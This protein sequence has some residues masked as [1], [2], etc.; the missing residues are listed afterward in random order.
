MNSAPHIP[1]KELLS[2]QDGFVRA[3]ALRLAPAPGLAED[4]AQQVF[5]EFL[6]KEAQWDTS[7]D[8]KPLLAVMTRN[9][10]R[11]CWRERMHTLPEVQRE[12]SEH[13]CRLAESRDVSWFGE[14]ERTVLRRCLDRLPTKS[15]RL[16]ELHY[17]MDTSS[18]EIAQQMA[19]QPDAV[20]RA[21]CRLR[22]QLRKCMSK[23]LREKS[24]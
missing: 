22:E 11:R 7:R 24:V 14:E 1:V 20:R 21:L 9:V 16:V 8:I 23:F 3:L 2:A 12:L 13:I 10:A 6:A 15:R 5:L 17:Y 18:V 19:M 4:I